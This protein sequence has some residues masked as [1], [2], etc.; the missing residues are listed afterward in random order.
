MLSGKRISRSGLS[1]HGS[2]R[3]KGEAIVLVSAHGE[4]ANVGEI[5]TGVRNAEASSLPSLSTNLSDKRAVGKA[6]ANLDVMAWQ[7][8]RRYLPE[9][10]YFLSLINKVILICIKTRNKTSNHCVFNCFQ[11]T[12]RCTTAS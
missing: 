11:L 2:Q 12:Y 3:C 1:C 8:E 5:N 10:N 9:Q 4:R 6:A 7:T